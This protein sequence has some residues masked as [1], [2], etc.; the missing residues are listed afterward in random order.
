MVQ[1]WRTRFTAWLF[2]VHWA[3]REE[4]ECSDV[5]AVENIYRENP[6]NNSTIGR[7][8][9]FLLIRQNLSFHIHS[10]I[11]RTI[12]NYRMGRLILDLFALFFVVFEVDLCLSRRSST[13]SSVEHSIRSC[14]SKFP[15]RNLDRS[16]ESD[17]RI[18]LNWPTV[19]ECFSS[20]GNVRISTWLLSSSFSWTLLRRLSR[21][22]VE[23][24]T[25]TS[26]SIMITNI[27]KERER[28]RRVS[29]YR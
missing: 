16:I 28:E 23:K 9:S 18:S 29:P 20:L 4:R 25:S 5:A 7:V 3:W 6:L 27:F 21:D 17:R 12:T 13:H 14:E 26:S 8:S 1:R 11:I 15:T 24:N 22:W 10:F 2:I 19:E